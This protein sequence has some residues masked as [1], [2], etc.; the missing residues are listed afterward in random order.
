M[1]G[2]GS[3]ILAARWVVA[4]VT[5]A[6]LGLGAVAVA[7]DAPQPAN[8]APAAPRL[9]RDPMAIFDP[10]VPLMPEGR[11]VSL[12]QAVEAATFPVPRPAALGTPAEVWVAGTGDG[13]REIDLRYPDRGVVVRLSAFPPAGLGDLETWAEARVEGLPLAYTTTIAGYPA[14]VLPYDPDLALAPMDVVYVAVG[15]VEMTI[16]GDHGRTDIEELTSAAATLGA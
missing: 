2:T 6:V 16:Y 4:F 9:A 12:E 1:T 10:S 7:G 5:G 8:P 14:A 15:G 13:V 11:Q 3:P